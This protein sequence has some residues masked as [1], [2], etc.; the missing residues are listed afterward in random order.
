M[1]DNAAGRHSKVIGSSPSSSPWLV[2]LVLAQPHA[3]LPAGE[4]ATVRRS[5]DKR[6]FV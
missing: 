2:P 6:S 5:N 4:T 1:T 3:R